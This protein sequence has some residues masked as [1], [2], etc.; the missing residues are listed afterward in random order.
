[1]RQTD[2]AME[3]RW[4]RRSIFAALRQP[5]KLDPSDASSPSV[6]SP[7]ALRLLVPGSGL[8]LLGVIYL[9]LASLPYYYRF[10]KLHP[11][12]M[13]HWATVSVGFTF[14]LICGFGCYYAAWR[15]A[16]QFAPTRRRILLVIGV[17]AIL[18]TI[19]AFTYPFLSDDMFYGIVGARTFGCY[20]QNPFAVPPS[21]FIH[22][23]FLP[24]AGWPD[25]TMPYGPL[26]VLISG[27]VAK[28]SDR[29]LLATVLAFKALN[30]SLFLLTTGLLARLLAKRTP[31]TALAGLVLWAWNPLV[32]VEVASSAHNDI[33]MITLIVAACSFAAARRA[34][35]ALLMLALAVAAKYVAIILVPFFA[36][37][38]LRRHA[39]WR[40][41][42]R[43][44]IPGAIVSASALLALY[45]PFWVG[46]QTFGPLG[47]ARYAYGSIIAAARYLLPRDHMLL[48]DTLL[49]GGALLVYG[50]CYIWLLRRTGRKLTDLF[51]IS[52]SALLF[53]LLLWPFFM[54]WYTLWL[55]PIAALTKRPR[56][57]RQIIVVTGAALATY[58]FQFFLRPAFRQSTDFWSTLSA[59][60]VF[61]SL[62]LVTLAPL[63]RNALRRM[64]RRFRGS[65]RPALGT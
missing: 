62:L 49:R 16:S 41:G 8:L 14:A 25:L 6:A 29:G 22:D 20:R 11:S 52:Y 39:N 15:I 65:L 13:G 42:V 18:S 48:H 57:A 24:Y 55:V 34:T 46:W 27:T 10:P 19:L 36:I 47:E 26:W 58:L 31:R 5:G 54:P 51:V 64:M 4:G 38:F 7:S 2:S 60:L 30:V 44:L 59:V 35:W 17:A 28:I 50:I 56:L 1:M 12:R 61:G 33:V 21:R 32:L 45:L 9:W 43:A 53:I 23:P 40:A 37:H 3:R 63:A